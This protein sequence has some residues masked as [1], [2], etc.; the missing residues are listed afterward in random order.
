[1]N[2]NLNNSTFY[3]LGNNLGKVELKPVT[4]LPTKE[5]K[6]V[7]GKNIRRLLSVAEIAKLRGV[8]KNKASELRR[9][10]PYEFLVEIAA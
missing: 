10:F 4:F 1:M 2:F 3:I 5:G 9:H 6:P 8:S 7:F